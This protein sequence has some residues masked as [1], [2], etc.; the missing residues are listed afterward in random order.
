MC[1]NLLKLIFME[2][3]WNPG[4]LTSVE[5]L[6]KFVDF[7]WIFVS[8]PELIFLFRD[9]INTSHGPLHTRMPRPACANTLVYILAY[10]VHVRIH[11][12][13]GI[14]IP[15]QIRDPLLCT[16]RMLTGPNRAYILIKRSAKVPKYSCCL[17]RTCLRAQ[18]LRTRSPQILTS[19]STPENYELVLQITI[20]SIPD[21]QILAA[22]TGRAYAPTYLRTSVPT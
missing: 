5:V 20:T 21:L 18:I 16:M 17:N 22:W 9:T 10:H 6:L 2:I 8:F 15:L 14:R 12:H 4:N 1:W 7:C 11:L 19:T 3:L 13:I